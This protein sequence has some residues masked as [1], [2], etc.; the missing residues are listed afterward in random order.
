MDSRTSLHGF[1]DIVGY[2]RL[3]PA[4]HAESQERLVRI[5]NASLRD[6]G[7]R[8]DCMSVQ[9]QGD[10]CMLTF[11]NDDLDVSRV[12]AVMPRRFNDE[13]RASNRDVAAHVRLRVRLAFAMGPSG[14]G[15][16]GRT[17]SVPITV[18]RLNNASALR[19]AMEAEPDAHLGVIV[20]DDLYRKHVAQ[21]FRPD[22][23]VDEYAE[24]H[25]SDPGKN[26]E[27]DAWIRLVGYRA[28]AI[29]GR[30]RGVGAAG[31]P[32]EAIRLPRSAPPSAGDPGAAGQRASASART[33]SESA[34]RRR[35]FRL[36]TASATIIAAAITGGVTLSIYLDSGNAG[37]TGSTPGASP[38]TGTAATA[39]R[40]TGTATAA[41][42]ATARPAIARRAA[43]GA[44]VAEYANWRPGV[45]IYANNRAATSNVRV[46]PFQQAVQVS[47]VAPNDSGIESI[48]AFYLIVTE[49]WKGTYA[50]ANE[51]SNGGPVGSSTV[52]AIDPRVHVCPAS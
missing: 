24:V 27:Q 3:T 7:V 49:P 43:S 50:S 16:I 10:A 25:V 4:Q 21:E 32:S 39:G 19:A 23:A 29:T 33:D 51:F 1:A 44:T 18:V 9:H 46:I 5:I 22:L 14:A 28:S 34:K 6:A 13:L 20:E 40:G 38:P 8:P 35:R 31:L 2:S 30:G 47:C 52:P 26:F 41:S 36:T 11:P 17:G 48:N 15:V 42:T 45:N 37:G 12:L